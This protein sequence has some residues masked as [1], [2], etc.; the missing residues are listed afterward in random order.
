M[1]GLIGVA[2]AIGVKHWR[3]FRDLSII[4]QVRGVD[5]YGAAVVTH[6]G[7]TKIFKDYLSPAEVLDPIPGTHKQDMR[8]LLGHNRWA[9]K[10][11]VTRD[12]CHPFRR[13]GVV[14]MHNGTLVTQHNLPVGATY[15]SDSR[16][17]IESI[18]HSGIE[19]VWSRLHGA[20]ALVWWN[21]K[22]H[23][24]CM[25]RNKERPL[26]FA[27]WSDHNGDA[28]VW[29]SEE[30]MIEVT[31]ARHFGVKPQIFTP[32]PN[33][34]FEFKFDDLKTGRKINTTTTEL[35]PYEPP[36]YLPTTYTYP[37][38]NGGQRADPFAGNWSGSWWAGMGDDLSNPHGE[39]DYC[40]SCL[41]LVSLNDADTVVLDAGSVVCGQCTA[42]MSRS[43]INNIYF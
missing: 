7:K 13:N 33:Y 21:K 2:G 32:K 37:K 8:V 41:N 34:L 24:L 11:K 20:A 1:C 12:N 6:T 31:L 18:A 14:G 9:T 42:G 25:L 17:L 38:Y 35:K 27:E 4:D 29:A 10:G 23:T 19:H 15:E 26:F 3:C 30:W 16:A 28:L 43:E 40:V 36:V 5:G 22:T 39:D